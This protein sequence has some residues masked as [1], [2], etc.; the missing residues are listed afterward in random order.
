[1]LYLMTLVGHFLDH[2]IELVKAGRKFVYVVDNVD[3]EERVH[4]MREAHQNKS[5]QAVASSIVFTMISSDHLPDDSPQKDVKTCNFRDI[6]NVSE[7][8]KEK[9]HNRYRMFVARA[10]IERFPGLAPL[11]VKPDVRFPRI[12]QHCCQSENNSLASSC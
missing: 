3:W 1:M 7:E 10:I 11:T 8:E 5:V 4:D 9:V 12:L 2:A 6:V